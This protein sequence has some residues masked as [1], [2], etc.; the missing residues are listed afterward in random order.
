MST[1]P[2]CWEDTGCT[3]DERK[4]ITRLQAQVEKLEEI[5][6]EMYSELVSILEGEYSAD[7]NLDPIAK[8]WLKAKG[9]KS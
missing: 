6:D 2:G 7:W 9:E 1:C 8:E 3:C 5:G 4:E